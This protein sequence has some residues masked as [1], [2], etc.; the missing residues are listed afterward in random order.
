MARRSPYEIMVDAAW[1][2]KGW[3]HSTAVI[4]APIM[5]RL[6]KFAACVAT[7]GALALGALWCWIAIAHEVLA[8]LTWVVGMGLVLAALRVRNRRTRVLLIAAAILF[9]AAAYV[10]AWD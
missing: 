3:D 1:A 7:L 9:I 5:W 8:G 6:A 4:V 10:T 2:R